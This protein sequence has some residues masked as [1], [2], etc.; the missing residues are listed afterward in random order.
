MIPRCIFSAKLHP[1]PHVLLLL[2]WNYVGAS[3]GDPDGA[4][5]WPSLE[6]LQDTLSVG[7]SS[8]YRSLATLV[9]DGWVERATRAVTVRGDTCSRRGFVL[10]LHRVRPL[11]AS[12]DG[13]G[14]LD[15]GPEGDDPI[16]AKRHTEAAS[17][18]P[19]VPLFGQNRPGVRTDLSHFSDTH[20]LQE[21]PV[22]DHET[23]VVS[24]ARARVAVAVPTPSQHDD[25]GGIFATA[26]Q[27]WDRYEVIRHRELGGMPPR[28]ATRGDLRKL[29]DLRV[30]VRSRFDATVK[31]D[32]DAWAMID[33]YGKAAVEL[34]REAR[35]A[36]RPIAHKLVGARCDGREWTPERLEAVLARVDFRPR[37][38]AVPAST[39]SPPWDADAEP[40]LTGEQTADL[41][42]AALERLRNGTTGETPEKDAMS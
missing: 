37:V 17:A 38:A 42:A 18:H 36:D 24:P 8:L 31:C 25:D 28:T 23:V 40:H 41:A 35:A 15:G 33:G 13:T 29:L 22:K 2:L 4:F 11:E 34:A 1:A 14:F 12:N 6:T 20:P 27:S 16:V 10:R 3:D 26:R 32:A 7:R 21:V 5:V 39:W 19:A 30:F 9:G